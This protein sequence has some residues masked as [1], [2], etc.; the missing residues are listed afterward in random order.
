MIALCF[1][2]QDH[3][4][5]LHGAYTTTTL[6]LRAA[7]RLRT[8]TEHLQETYIVLEVVLDNNSRVRRVWS[9]RDG[10]GELQ[11]SCLVNTSPLELVDADGMLSALAAASDECDCQACAEV[12]REQQTECAQELDELKQAI[13]RR[14]DT[15]AEWQ[16]LAREMGV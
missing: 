11:V 14:K 5:V 4:F 7:M 16:R 10:D 13:Q 12:L 1:S 6:A 8:R 9:L 15:L 3:S 2:S